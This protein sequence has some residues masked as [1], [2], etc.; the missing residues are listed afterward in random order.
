[1]PAEEGCTDS[2][3]PSE[4]IPERKTWTRAHLPGGCLIR[5]QVDNRSRFCVMYVALT[6]AHEEG[7]EAAE[8]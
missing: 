7:M 3:V 5:R 1:M 6:M 2:S 4:L 8:L